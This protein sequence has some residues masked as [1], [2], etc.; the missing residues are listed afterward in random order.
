VKEV[1][2]ACAEETEGEEGESEQEESADLEAALGL[3]GG[4]AGLIWSRV[5]D[6][7]QPFLYSMIVPLAVSS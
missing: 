5:C 1:V 2:D 4:V 7:G 6:S 3:S